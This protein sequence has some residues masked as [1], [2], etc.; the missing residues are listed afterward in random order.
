MKLNPCKKC[1]EIPTIDITHPTWIGWIRCKCGNFANTASI[2]GCVGVWN[3]ANPVE[4]KEPEPTTIYIEDR[5]KELERRVS[6]L[7]R[8]KKEN[9]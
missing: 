2:L 7:E 1:G 4:E 6:E 5:I 9:K 8:D 3:D